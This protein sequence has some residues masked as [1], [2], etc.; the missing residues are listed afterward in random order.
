M[1]INAGVGVEVRQIY[2]PRRRSNHPNDAPRQNY[3]NPNFYAGMEKTGSA[4]L[5]PPEQQAEGEGTNNYM[6]HV[7]VKNISYW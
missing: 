4:S 1:K 5:L 2:L 3:P 6:L 7:F